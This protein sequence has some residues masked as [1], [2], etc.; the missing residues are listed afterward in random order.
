MGKNFPLSPAKTFCAFDPPPLCPVESMITT[1][2]HSRRGGNPLRYR[3][4]SVRPWGGSTSDAARYFVARDGMSV[5]YLFVGSRSDL[6]SVGML[7]HPITEYCTVYTLSNGACVHGIA[8]QFSTNCRASRKV[9]LFF[10]FSFFLF[11]FLVDTI[12]DFG[13]QTS[14]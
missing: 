5:D 1:V 4:R 11:P 12:I 3:S 10:P 9:F 13:G 14:G 6:V 2:D 7:T 8:D